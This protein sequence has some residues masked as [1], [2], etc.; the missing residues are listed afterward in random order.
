MISPFFLLCLPVLVS[1]GSLLFPGLVRRFPN[2]FGMGIALLFGA[3]AICLPGQGTA[4]LSIPWVPQLSMELAF[5]MTPFTAWFGFLIFFLGACVHLYACSYFA[6]NPRLPSL[7]ASLTLFTSAML[8]V[9]WS[10]NLLLLF[11]F[12]EAT[13]LLSFL[14]VGFFH[15]KEQSRDNASQALLITML[16]G[17][18]LLVGFVLLQIATGTASI[19]Q[20]LE[21]TG[22]LPNS[23][24]MTGAVLL[25]ILGAMTKS[26][27]WPFHFWLPN[28][29][30]GPSPVSA[31]LHSATMVKAGVFL[32]A[33]LAPL[34]GE[35]PLWTPILV[36]SGLLTVCTAIVRGAWE[37]DLKAVLAS[38]TLAAL[39]FLTI[40][41]GIGSPS[42]LLAFVIFLT[43]H[44]LYK[45]PLFLAAGNF[46]KRTGTRQLS[47]LQGASSL[48]PV[49]GAVVLI[50]VLSLI[51]LAPLP[52]FLGK[53]YLLEAAWEF[54]PALACAIAVAAAGVIALGLRI[55]VP[56]LSRETKPV[57][58][59][60]IPFGM[61]A[62]TFIPALGA[63]IL[64]ILIPT[65][66]TNL[67]SQAAIS[68][69]ASE[70]SYYSL[71][72]GWNPALF[73]SLGAL[74]LSGVIFLALRR[75]RHAALPR[76]FP[77]LWEGL[78]NLTLRGLRRLADGVSV[79]LEKGRLT[80][81]L[82][83]LLTA[84]GL[85]AFLSL[86]LHEWPSLPLTWSGNSLIFLCLT[87]LL[88]VSAII[89]A[90]TRKTLPLLVSLGF[91]GLL[92][93]FLF[94][95][96]SAPD[97]ALTQL[98]AETLILFLLAVALIRD[99]QTP[100]TSP[101]SP[102]VFRF[103][104]ASLGGILV[105]AL[106]LKSMALEWD[107]PIS[108]FHLSQSKP[109]AFGANVVNVI[110]VDFRALDTLGEI[111]VLAIAAMG[112]NS[113]LGAA[114]VRAH[115]PG[116]SNT[117]L[118]RTGVRLVILFLIPTALWIF[119]RGH[120][121]PGGGFIAA[122]L[123]ASA[124]GLGL[125]CSRP[126][127]TAPRLRKASHI[128]LVAGLAI[129]LGTALLP[130]AIGRPFFAG[131]WFHSGSLHLRTPLLFDLGVFL[132]V[133]GFSLNYLRHFHHRTL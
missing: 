78:F 83:I 123:A 27:Q 106:I 11:L 69:G 68:L 28:A 131:M 129:A 26:A 18:A 20:L 124:V 42:A 79:I 115:L 37:D 94:L 62:A 118:L 92:I 99:K 36:T 71:W 127:F 75:P 103:I 14:L 51:G 38:T 30:V 89:A 72:H 34:L 97:L 93:A 116:T 15:E 63:L 54:S 119:W 23:P 33:T 6:N 35:H 1:L 4:H 76:F 100:R 49:T 19:T 56:I 120:N 74:A 86:D 81:H 113:A 43:A 44:A 31:F 12:W 22:E 101:E 39:G 58:R 84:I 128:L 96:F 91:V 111:I 121:A 87:P 98:L 105:T 130:L 82:A 61:S 77:P 29:M 2:Q 122:L 3:A 59:N 80:S 133:L 95:W 52:G 53:E 46:E 73:L 10:D 107:H 47:E 21:R 114:R 90:R 65:G 45:A 48:A 67:L 8:G 7:L 102:C 41:A 9:I 16:G 85:L 132:T 112:A 55:A 126:D 57:S 32:M 25:I 110:L 60:G 109:A 125:L 66:N 108:D 70:G 13:S 24:V 117:S 88:A 50:S 17:A 40:L 104:F 64:T 5:R